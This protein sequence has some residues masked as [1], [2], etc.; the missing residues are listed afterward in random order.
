MTMRRRSSASATT[1]SRSV[2]P[3]SPARPDGRMSAQLMSDAPLDRQP[4]IILAWRIRLGEIKQLAEP[5]PG[6]GQVLPHRGLRHPQYARD[7]ASLELI[8]AQGEDLPLQ[9]RKLPD[10]E[11]HSVLLE[12]AFNTRVIGWGAEL[13]II[14]EQVFI[15]HVRAAKLAHCYFPQPRPVMMDASP[16]LVQRH[17]GA[18]SCIVRVMITSTAVDQITDQP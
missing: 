2:S 6:P 10:R 11:E 16:S 15:G 1:V 13:I 9:L 17:E 18:L 7:L 14:I 4:E 12:E 8:E 3:G 5:G